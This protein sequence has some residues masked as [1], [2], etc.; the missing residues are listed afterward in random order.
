MKVADVRGHELMVTICKMIGHGRGIELGPTAEL[1][2]KP[3]FGQPVKLPPHL[4]HRCST[5]EGVFITP[6]SGKGGFN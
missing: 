6:M 2:P 3:A 1:T 5:C 4:D